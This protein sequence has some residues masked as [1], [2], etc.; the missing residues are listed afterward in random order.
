MSICH[1]RTG[2]AAGIDS[3]RIED[4]PR[5]GRIRIEPATEQDLDAVADM[6][7]A[8]LTENM[9]AIGD[10]VFQVDP[11]A[12]RSLV[13]EFSRRDD[14]W[15]FVARSDPVSAVGLISVNSNL[16]SSAHQPVAW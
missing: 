8:L 16:A 2:N 10:Q 4:G 11:V 13:A 1:T 14:Y 6:V 9:A 12:A 3:R 5:P 7:G 15:V